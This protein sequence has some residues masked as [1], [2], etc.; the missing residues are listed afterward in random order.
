MC[1]KNFLW[2][3]VPPI[4]MRSV[5]ARRFD[6][7]MAAIDLTK[8]SQDH[9]KTMCQLLEDT[10]TE[11]ASDGKSDLLAA[12]SKELKKHGEFMSEAADKKFADDTPQ[13]RKAFKDNIDDA[14]KRLLKLMDVI[15]RLNEIQSF[16]LLERIEE[17]LHGDGEIEIEKRC[18]SVYKKM[19]ARLNI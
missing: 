11:Y 12:I 7:L 3:G 15:D 1:S 18:A 13:N 5:V 4:E 10:A 9:F 2:D 6:R 8:V 19:Q 17:V 14:A 16:A